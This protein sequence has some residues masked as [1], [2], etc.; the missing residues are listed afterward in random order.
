MKRDAITL[1]LFFTGLV[2][3]VDLHLRL[4]LRADRLMQ[5]RDVIGD[6]L[7]VTIRQS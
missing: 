4:Q 3:P 6:S 7:D 2:G 5:A 1:F